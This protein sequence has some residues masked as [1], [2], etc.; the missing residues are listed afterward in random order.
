MAK[1][2]SQEIKYDEIISW[3]IPEYEKHDRSFRWYV[4]TGIIMAILAG[5]SLF[6]PNWLFDTPN[7][8]FLIIILL[9]GVTMILLNAMAGNIEFV[10]TTEGFIIGDRF[11][12]FDNFKNFCVLYKPRENLKVLYLEFRGIF[13]PRLTVPLQDVNPLEVRDILL[14]YLTEDLER[15]DESN[16]DFLSRIFKI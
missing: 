3:T 4:I 8:L 14:D 13:R 15:T 16:M 5:F 10:I 2:E 1:R 12:D 6:T 7:Y 9:S 11:Y